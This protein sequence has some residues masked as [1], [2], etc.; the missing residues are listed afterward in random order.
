ME[1]LGANTFV[2]QNYDA[3]LLVAQGSVNLAGP[4][5]DFGSGGSANVFITDSGTAVTAASLEQ[6]VSIIPEP[7][8]ATMLLLLAA[9]VVLARRRAA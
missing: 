8:A 4:L 7:A 3:K 2:Q 9:P 1:G 6:V 5:P